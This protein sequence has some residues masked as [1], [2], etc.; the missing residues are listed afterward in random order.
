MKE[1]RQTKPLTPDGENAGNISND[2]YVRVRTDYYKILEKPIKV[3]N[4]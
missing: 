4:D 1:E 3:Q 2:R